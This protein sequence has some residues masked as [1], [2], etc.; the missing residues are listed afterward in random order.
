MSE[1]G[2]WGYLG[3][4]AGFVVML[5]MAL[6]F[7]VFAYKPSVTGESEQ[8]APQGSHSDESTTDTKRAA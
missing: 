8:A 6:F 1:W 2:F 3:I 4:V 5:A 7:L